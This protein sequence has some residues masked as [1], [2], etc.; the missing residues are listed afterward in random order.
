MHVM[1]LDMPPVFT[2]MHGDAVR[3]AQLRLDG[4]PDGIRFIGLSRLPHG[5][6]VVD[7]DTQL[8]HNSCNSMNTRRDCSGLPPR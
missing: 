3:P 4:G 5:S 1:V 8:N 2:Q 6:Y 7:I